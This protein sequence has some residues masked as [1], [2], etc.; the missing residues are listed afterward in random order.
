MTLGM[1]QRSERKPNVLNPFS[2]RTKLQY[3]DIVL[4]ARVWEGFSH[5]TSK[6]RPYRV[7]RLWV[8]EPVR[9]SAH[10]EFPFHVWVPSIL[11]FYLNFMFLLQ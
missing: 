5:H 4:V 8:V 7:A 9:W 10:A 1:R 11:F 2:R 6:T 3:Y